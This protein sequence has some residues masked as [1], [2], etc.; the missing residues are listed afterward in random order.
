MQL[1][2]AQG[3]CTSCRHA[4]TN[5][6]AFSTK[7]VVNTFRLR[8]ILTSLASVLL[9]TSIAT[10]LGAEAPATFKVGEFSFK[11]PASWEWV[12]SSSPMRKAQL[13][14]AD[15]AQKESAEVVFF[16]FGEGGGGGTKANVDR[17]LGLFQEPREKL[18]SK[19]EE[20]AVNQRK[21]TYVQAQGTY[22]SGMP[23]GA[24]TPQPNTMLLGAILESPAG[25]VFVRL[26]GPLKLSTASQAA[27]RKMVEGDSNK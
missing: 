8:I 4:L 23:G 18:Q 7:L 24:K 2:Q 9:L 20:V 11:R 3:L 13:K 15:A 14:I 21:I 17:W 22:M 19:V 26:T 5:S 16:Y 10:A 6:T 12:E 27:F 25:S 1:H